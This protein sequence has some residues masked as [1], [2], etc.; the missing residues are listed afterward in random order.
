[1]LE[2]FD[3]V[4][5]KIVDLVETIG[6]VIDGIEVC[7]GI[8]CLESGVNFELQ[9]QDP[10]LRL[11]IL[12]IAAADIPQGRRIDELCGRQISEV[13]TSVYWPSVGM[14]VDEDWLVYLNSETPAKIVVTATRIGEKYGP[15][16]YRRYFG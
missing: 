3:I 8:L 13:V 2:R 7:R 11:P 5:Q 16:D 15:S 6:V 4:G 9:S 14:I 12:A 1:M 10:L